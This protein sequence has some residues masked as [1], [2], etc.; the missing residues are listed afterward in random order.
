[1]NKTT[2]LSIAKQYVRRIKKHGIPVAG[3]FVFGSQVKGGSHT[4]SDIDVCI[5]SRLF[6]SDRQ[7]ERLQLMRLTD[8]ETKRIEPH[9][10]GL[11][12]LDNIYDP[13][14]NEIRRTGV[15]V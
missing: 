13:L 7:A 5:V 10:Y 12:E 1:M 11:N 2:A 6:G 14:A 8:S 15:R 9:P 3:A 4:W